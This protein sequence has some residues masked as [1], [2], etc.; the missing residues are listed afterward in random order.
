MTSLTTATEI[1]QEVVRGGPRVVPMSIYEDFYSYK[2]GI[3]THV[4]GYYQGGHAMKMLGYG[5]TDK[6]ELY[7]I[8]QNQWGSGWGEKGFINVLAGQIGIDSMGMSCDPDF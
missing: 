8:L 7:W 2:S 4:S 1:M 5:Y 6:D 3:Y